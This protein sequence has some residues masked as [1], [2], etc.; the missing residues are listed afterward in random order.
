MCVSTHIERLL[1]PIY[2]RVHNDDSTLVQ[3]MRIIEFGYRREPLPPSLRLLFRSTEQKIRGFMVVQVL[4]IQCMRNDA[5]F[6]AMYVLY[7]V[8]WSSEAKNLKAQ[9]HAF[10]KQSCQGKKHSKYSGDCADGRHYSAF[11]SLDVE[12]R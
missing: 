5:K 7:L 4:T 11:K 9:S 3:S 8:Q 12:S 10:V 1:V 2:L 6:L